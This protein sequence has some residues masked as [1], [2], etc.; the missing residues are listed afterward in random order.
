MPLGGLKDLSAL[1]ALRV[2]DRVAGLTR[3]SAALT[4]GRLRAHPATFA[5]R[6]ALRS[7]VRLAT[8]SVKT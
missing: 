5:D 6:W 3:P 1:V 7:P 4:L 8:T 2:G